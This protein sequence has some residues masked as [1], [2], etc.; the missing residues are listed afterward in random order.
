M[1]ARAPPKGV[2]QT[3]FLTVLFQTTLVVMTVRW[4]KHLL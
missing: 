3:P 1:A 4:L 2:L